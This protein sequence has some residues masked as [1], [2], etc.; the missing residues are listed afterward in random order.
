MK[1]TAACEACNTRHPSDAAVAVGRFEQLVPTGY[2][3]RDVPG[4]PL[5]ATREAAVADFCEHQRR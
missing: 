3:A 4:A 1:R 2:M 5:R